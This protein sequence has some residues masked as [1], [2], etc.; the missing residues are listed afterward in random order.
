MAGAADPRQCAGRMPRCYARD[1]GRRNA[2]AAAVG[3]EDQRLADPQ[4]LESRDRKSLLGLDRETVRGTARRSR[5]HGRRCMSCCAIP[6]ATCCTI[7]SA[8]AKTP[9]ISTSAPIAPT[10][11]ISCAPISPSRWACPTATRNARAAAAATR[12]AARSGGISRRKSRGPKRLRTSSPPKTRKRPVDRRNDRPAIFSICSSRSSHPRKSPTAN[13]PRHRSRRPRRARRR[14][15]RSRRHPVR[16]RRLRQSQSRLHR[17]GRRGRPRWRWASAITCNTASPTACIPAPGARSRPMKAPTSTRSR[18]PNRRCVPARS[19]PIPYG[20][21]LIIAKRVPQTDGN[22][23]VFLA[24]DAQPDGTVARKRFWRGNFL[25]AQEPALGDAGFKRFRPIVRDK[26][27][28]LRRLTVAEIAKNPNY[29][30]LLAGADQALGRRLLRQDGRRD[31]AQPARSAGCD[32]GS[33]HLARGAGEGARHLGRERPQVSAQR[34]GRRL[35]AGRRRDL[36]DHRRVGGF[37]HA[38]ARSAAA[39]RDGR[40]APFPRAR[41][42]AAGA[43][44]DAEGQ[45]RRCR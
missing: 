28:A 35:D 10:C 31:V 2:A 23:G 15:S 1:R 27:G 21:L 13:H 8:C 26:G 5:R 24:V 33:D 18:C 44:R 22:A 17:C 40:G 29:C 20:H 16:R 42:A 30:G 12:R 14:A 11:R 41:G 25:F 38:L 19:M 6:R 36:R 32:E 37:R 45:E 39:D 34:Q 3:I 7:I 4:F 43:L 9:S